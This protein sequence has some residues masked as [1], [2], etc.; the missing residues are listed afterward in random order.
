MLST[1]QKTQEQ[2]SLVDC[3]ILQPQSSILWQTLSDGIFTLNWNS[4]RI[5][6]YIN[7]CN[8]AV[9]EFQITV[10]QVHRNA[11]MIEDVKAAIS[12][13]TLIRK[14]DFLGPTGFPVPAMSVTEFYDTIEMNR[15]SR[16][17][18][19]STKYRNV[20]HYFN[21]V[22]SCLHTNPSLIHRFHVSILLTGSSLLSMLLLLLLLLGTSMLFGK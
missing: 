17:G 16:L 6:A 1:Y 19:L 2:L 11:S 15:V 8:K 3:T 7:A 20:E 14:S 4:Q 10:S 5:N 21:K 9:A 18:K 22:G 12:N 13:E